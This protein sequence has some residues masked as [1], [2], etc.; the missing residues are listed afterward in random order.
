MKPWAGRVV[1]VTAGPTRE[2]MDPVRFLTNASTGRMGFCLAEAAKNLGAKVVLVSGPTCLEDPR[3]VDVK[4]V[5]T[6]AEMRRAALKSS[7]KA[8]VFIA[9]AAVGDWRFERVAPHK[10]KREKKA[11][12]VRL[13][14]NPDIVAEVARGSRRPRLVVGFALES[15]DI[16]ENARKKLASKNLD[17]VVANGL[18]TLGSS[19]ARVDILYR[20]GG[21]DTLPARSKPA[22]ARAILGKLG[23]RL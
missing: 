20:D 8:D 6:A 9:A 11:V 1:V 19:S 23:E 13:V 7:S 22:A 15:R 14:P 3:G 16:L 18:E 21:R 5:T 4:R 10:I 2:P 12:T 17:A